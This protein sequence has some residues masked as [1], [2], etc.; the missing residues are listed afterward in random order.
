MD[1]YSQCI[2]LSNALPPDAIDRTSSFL[3]NSERVECKV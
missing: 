2:V 3:K 1:S